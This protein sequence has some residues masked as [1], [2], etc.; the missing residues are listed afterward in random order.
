MPPA[1]ESRSLNHWTTSEVPLTVYSL[2]LCWTAENV[3]LFELLP[4][5]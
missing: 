4:A 2:S 1:L 5:F 3:N